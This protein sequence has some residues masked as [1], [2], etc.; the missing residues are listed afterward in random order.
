[1]SVFLLKLQAFILV[2]QLQH[3][4]CETKPKYTSGDLIVTIEVYIKTLLYD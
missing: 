2:S 3:Y 1:M 4:I